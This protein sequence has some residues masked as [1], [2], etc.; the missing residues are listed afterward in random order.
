M[1]L[2]GA[3]NN[4]ELLAPRPGLEPGT[5]RLT[6]SGLNEAPRVSGGRLLLDQDS[7]L[8]PPVKSAHPGFPGC[9]WI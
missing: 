4:E 5:W 1:D 2:C 9:R 8:E 7:N 6:A 3:F